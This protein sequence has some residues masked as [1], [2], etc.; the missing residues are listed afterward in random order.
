VAVRLDT[1]RSA[2][3]SPTQAVMSAV[4][5]D[6]RDVIVDGEA[7]VTDG[8]HRLGDVARLLRESIEP[9]WAEQPS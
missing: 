3:G 8:V 9:L 1:V 2:G 7:V 4:A 5:P 6:V